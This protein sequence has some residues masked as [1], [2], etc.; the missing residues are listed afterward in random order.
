MSL[1]DRIRV[2]AI[3]WGL[4]YWTA[5]VA[6]HSRQQVRRLAAIS[7]LAEIAVRHTPPDSRLVGALLSLLGDESDPVAATAADSL[8][9]IGDDLALKPLAA[10]LDNANVNRRCA[11]A[12]ALVRL[13]PAGMNELIRALKETRWAGKSLAVLRAIAANPTSAEA[14]VVVALVTDPNS[15]VRMAAVKTLESLGESGWSERVHGAD[16]DL[17][18]VAETCDPRLLAPLLEQLE[19]E[20]HTVVGPRAHVLVEAIGRLRSELAVWPLACVLE[21]GFLA[22]ELVDWDKSA[23]RRSRRS[24]VPRSKVDEA[25]RERLRSGASRAL[26]AIGGPVAREALARMLVSEEPS[27]RKAAAAALGELG[28]TCWVQ[29]VRGDANDRL[30]LLSCDDNTVVSAQL[31]LVLNELRS[32]DWNARRQAAEL[33]VSFASEHPGVALAQSWKKTRDAVQDLHQDSRSHH[34]RNDGAHSDGRS[35]SHDDYMYSEDG[36]C[37]KG[38]SSHSDS[39]RDAHSDRAHNDHSVHTDERPGLRFP[40]PTRSDIA[41]R[42]V[43]PEAVSLSACSEEQ[44]E[45]SADSRPELDWR[46]QRRSFGAEDMEVPPGRK[47]CSEC[48]SVSFDRVALCPNCKAPGWWR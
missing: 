42:D 39:Y 13:G 31:K 30:R 45:Q 44:S 40:E 9:L 25:A 43:L 11:A 28:E 15:D 12:Q 46:C 10:M 3:W 23:T 33:L 16:D 4:A 29:A 48:S 6:L 1:I 20:C 7:R 21:H 24:T 32:N 14:E 37:W 36:R 38:G 35:G 34:D 8:G 17:Q 26:A 5:R 18:R 2:W 22:W 47:S 41:A 19:S 27:L